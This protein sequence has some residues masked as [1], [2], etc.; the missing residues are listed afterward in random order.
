MRGNEFILF[1][2]PPRG[3][4][5]GCLGSAGWME[6]PGVGNQIYLFLLS[7]V[8]RGPPLSPFPLHLRIYVAYPLKRPLESTKLGQYDVKQ[9]AVCVGRLKN[10]RKGQNENEMRQM[11][12]NGDSKVNVIK[13]S[14]KRPANV[15]MLAEMKSQVIKTSTNRQSEQG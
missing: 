2:H 8:T 10:E 7:L 5:S 14:V 13:Q 3:Q 6:R 15:Q 11:S 9:L 1:S 12:G 4:Q